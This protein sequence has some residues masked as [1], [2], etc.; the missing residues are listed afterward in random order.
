MLK[1]KRLNCDLQKSF[2]A[3]LALIVTQK[4]NHC[5]GIFSKCMENPDQIWGFFKKINIH[6]AKNL[7]FWIEENTSKDS[8]IF[9]SCIFFC[10]KFLAKEKCV[11]PIILGLVFAF[12]VCC[13]PLGFQQK[14]PV[15]R[16]QF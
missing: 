6:Q 16:A 14:F 9:F 1:S 8:L 11:K 2:L 15:H 5:Q 13:L 12:V 7:F 4:Q 3:T 10:D